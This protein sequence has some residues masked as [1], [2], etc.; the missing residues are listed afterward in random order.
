MIDHTE[1][2]TLFSTENGVIHATE[3]Q[4]SQTTQHIISQLKQTAEDQLNRLLQQE[5]TMSSLHSNLDLLMKRYELEKSYFSHAA[6]WY[7]TKPWWGKILL[8][9]IL[10]GVGA[11]I[12]AIFHIPIAI[13]CLMACLY[14]ISGYFLMNHYT[15]SEKRNKRICE[16]IVE[17]EKS[18]AESIEHLSALEASLKK[19]MISLCKMN[20]QMADN[21]QHLEKQLHI[22]K[23]QL[24]KYTQAIQ[25]LSDTKDLIMTNA[26]TI[27]T[28]LANA[29]HHYKT[30][31][32]TLSHETS[33][34]NHLQ[35]AITGTNQ[36]LLADHEKLNQVCDQ[37]HQTAINLSRVTTLMQDAM[38]TLK[39]HLNHD[40]TTSGNHTG[41]AL[42]DDIT[43]PIFSHADATL[44]RALAQ[45]NEYNEIQK[46]H[47][48]HIK[49]LNVEAKEA[50][51]ANKL[52]FKR[53]ESLLEDKRI[54]SS[55]STR[56]YLS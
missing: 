18:L 40:H 4:S 29:D 27:N 48:H 33:A 50:A 54:K 11:G 16:D 14:L 53:A 36:A 52:R 42:I 51:S 5:R 30:C 38:T 47:D 43:D 37:F 39:T 24:D 20:S 17:M 56:T 13:G 55:K 41:T 44:M 26:N 45:V 3:S 7:G 19:V 6:D 21:L 35:S 49:Q 1:Y 10:I 2:L 12:G 32:D 8:G 22:M 15:L 28:E 34:I 31:H 25:A 23:I 9:L 46:I